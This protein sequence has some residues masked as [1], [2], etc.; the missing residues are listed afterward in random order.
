MKKRKILALVF[1]FSLLAIPF[2]YTWGQEKITKEQEKELKAQKNVQ[3][4]QE[5]E[6]KAIQKEMIKVK[7]AEHKRA[8]E[9]YRFQ[10]NKGTGYTTIP[11]FPSPPAI[12][13]TMGG[14][15]NSFSL[16]LMKSFK[17]E[18]TTKATS[19]TVDD[20]QRKI[21]F[22]V[23]GRCEEG[24]ITVSFILPSGKSF[25]KIQIDSSADIEWSQSLSIDEGSIYKGQWKV[26]IKAEKAKGMYQVNIK[27][28]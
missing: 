22:R 26:Q 15:E 19:F 1:I 20:D 12:S 16:S 2:S 24:N 13:W 4:A 27:T 25:T 23:S 11:S 28:D 10:Y 21:R 6:L 5:K 18:T 3:M 7:E 14:S 17:G 9:L 8:A